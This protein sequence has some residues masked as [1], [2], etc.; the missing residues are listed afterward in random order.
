MTLSKTLLLLPIIFF[1]ATP[2]KAENQVQNRIEERREVRQ[3]IQEDR[4]EMRQENVENRQELRTTIVQDKLEMRRQNA[5][6]IANNIVSKFENRFNYL[7]KIKAR[8]QLKITNQKTIRD[9][10]EAQKKLDLYDTT[11]YATDLAALKAKVATIATIDKPQTVVPALKEVT[12]LIQKDLKDLHQYLVDVLK[13][14]VK[15]PKIN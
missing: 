15:A 1:A 10:T 12:K 14:M 8:L 4:Q 2:V 13:L 5:I 9:M 6:K 3:E 11:K 7:E